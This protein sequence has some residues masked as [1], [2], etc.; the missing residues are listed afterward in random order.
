MIIDQI[1]HELSVWL[2]AFPTHK[3]QIWHFDF[4]VY[5]PLCCVVC[6]CSACTVIMLFARAVEHRSD[7]PMVHAYVMAKHVISSFKVAEL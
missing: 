3:R 5:L 6:V 4:P 7:S 2:P 1:Y